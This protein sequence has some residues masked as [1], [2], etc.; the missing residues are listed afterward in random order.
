MSSFYKEK[1][2]PLPNGKIKFMSSNVCTL[3]DFATGEKWDLPLPLYKK[4]ESDF[5]QLKSKDKLPVADMTFIQYWLSTLSKNGF[6]HNILDSF[7]QQK[8]MD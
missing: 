1:H 5:L 2:Q 7:N 3:I 6:N 4:Y 8:S